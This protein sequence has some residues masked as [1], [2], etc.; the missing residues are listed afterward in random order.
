MLVYKG[1][2]L[3]NIRKLFTM[4]I[5]LIGG[6]GSFIGIFITYLLFKF[7][8]LNFFTPILENVNLEFSFIPFSLFFNLILL[9]IGTRAAIKNSS[10]KIMDLRSNA[11]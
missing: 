6:M 8:I 9:Y 5:L 2:S 3:K 7:N 4:N 10:K 1:E 11:T